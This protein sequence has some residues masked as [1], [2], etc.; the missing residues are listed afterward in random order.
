VKSGFVADGIEKY[1]TPQAAAELILA[2]TSIWIDHFRS[3]NRELRK[4]LEQG[5]IVTHPFI[6]A[7]L[8]LV[9]LRERIRRERIRT[10]ALFD[11]LPQLRAAQ[12]SEVRRMIEDRR[13]YNVGVGLTDAH[14][15][16]SV[17]LNPSTELWTKDKPLRKAA[18]ELGI[19]VSLG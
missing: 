14:L 15:I 5:Q 1:S 3:G 9:S 13:L 2:D 18:E 6:V 19:H 16:A 7:G 12:L 10:L 11:L 17:L 8:A 4:R